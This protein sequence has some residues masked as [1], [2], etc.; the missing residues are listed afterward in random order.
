MLLEVKKRITTT[1]LVKAFKVIA[2]KE[3]VVYTGPFLL[4]QVQPDEWVT[5]KQADDFYMNYDIGY[6]CFKS[7][8]MADRA[9]YFMARR[10]LLSYK[11][12]PHHIVPV[13]LRGDVAFGTYYDS[14]KGVKGSEMLVKE[15][16][17]P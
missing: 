7:R 14:F 4:E 5:A 2:I 13:Y 3:G 8:R 1:K 10:G 6:H 15:K 16:H 17:L 9:L 11:G 12:Y